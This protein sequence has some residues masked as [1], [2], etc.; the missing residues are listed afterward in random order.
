MDD[1]EKLA[2]AF[3]EQFTP[4]NPR[5]VD[6][7]IVDEM[8]QRD[9]RT[10]PPLSKRELR[11][12]LSH[13]SN[14]S[15]AGPDHVN[16]YWLKQIISDEHECD[17][18]DPNH[19]HQNTETPIIAFFNACI[20]QGVHPA[21][22]KKSCTVVIP[23][24]NKSD[25]SQAKAYRP[26]VLLNCL[27][28]LLEKILARRLQFDAQKHGILHPGQFGG[29]IQHSTH[30]AGIQLIH[31]VQQSW[32]RGV[33]ST[34]LLLDVSQFF[35]SIHHETMAAILRKQGF[36]PSLCQYFKD[37]LVGRRTKFL[38]NGHHSQ[39]TNFSTGVGQG[40]ALSPIL[41]GLY[42]APALHLMAP[43][44]KAIPGNSILQFF[45]DDGL[46]HVAGRFT[47]VHHRRDGLIYNNLLLRNI[48]ESILTNLQRLGLG[49]ETDKLE[50]MHFWR[51]REAVWSEREPLGP[52]LKLC[53]DGQ[54][55]TLKPKRIM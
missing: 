8:S 20:Q 3:Q 10:F 38:F 26:I 22:F 29:V 19:D 27:E 46:I 12:A 43:T 34:A 51:A 30:D 21:V 18:D 45:V 52:S 7:S 50:L 25:Y 37:Y 42:I 36:H 6:L 23:K 13:T 47:P 17:C 14:V 53:I 40:S 44:D 11:I 5:P 1:P 31:N 4:T 48:F 2:Q 28:K 24:P 41:T 33:D 54:R 15:A 39:P 35:P 16:W 49:V 9:E 55:V 32:H